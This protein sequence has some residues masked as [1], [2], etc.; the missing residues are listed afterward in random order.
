MT[1]IKTHFPI[2]KRRGCRKCHMSGI[3]F[4]PMWVVY[5]D[6]YSTYINGAVFRN[7]VYVCKRCSDVIETTRAS[8]ISFY[9]KYMDKVLKK[10]KLR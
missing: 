3:L 8:A 6:R 4:K 7:R 9:H 10:L 1:A 2:F 5:D